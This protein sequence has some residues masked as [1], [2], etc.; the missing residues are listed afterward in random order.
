MV[1]KTEWGAFGWPSPCRVLSA[2]FGSCY[3]FHTHHFSLRHE[4]QVGIFLSKPAWATWHLQGRHLP[5]CCSCFKEKWYDPF[6]LAGAEFTN[7][8]LCC[9]SGLRD[10]SPALFPPRPPPASL[11]QPA[12]GGEVFGGI[13]LVEMHPW[14]GAKLSYSE[15]EKEARGN[16]DVERCDSRNSR[17]LHQRKPAWTFIPGLI[18]VV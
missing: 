1:V 2:C 5:T 10:E 7:D 15:R 17:T 9:E 16:A 11:P 4:Q 14:M 6:I 3:D 18:K 12:T 13:W 8:T